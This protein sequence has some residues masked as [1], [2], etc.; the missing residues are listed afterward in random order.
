MHRLCRC[1]VI[2][3]LSAAALP[4]AHAQDRAFSPGSLI[5]PMDL[6]YQPDGMEQA[7]GASLAGVKKLVEK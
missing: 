5:I 7:Y 4:R 2:V 6:E 1:V 3:A